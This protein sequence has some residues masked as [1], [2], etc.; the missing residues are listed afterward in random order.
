M[1][2]LFHPTL[3][4]I[5]SIIISTLFFTCSLN[6]NSD[7]DYAKFINPM[8]G[9]D[10]HGHTFPGATY[11]FGMVQLSPDTRLDTWDGCSG[12]HYSDHSIL[13]FSHTHFSGTGGGGG[14]DVMLMPTV[15]K[16]Q[17]NSGSTTNTLSGYRSKFL[18]KEELAEPG[19]YKVKLQDDDIIAEL[20][21][22]PRVGFHK[23]SFPSNKDANVILD[24]THGISDI[25]DSLQLE[26]VSDTEVSGFRESYEGLGGNHKIFFIAKFL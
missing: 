19:Y 2:K 17:L 3:I 10:W 13:G 23:Y 22:T 6:N 25:V 9:T 21:S 4:V 26:I 8:V 11:P 24:L 18:H 15:G 1:N 12:Y 20:T 7:K 5:I 14:G 16:I